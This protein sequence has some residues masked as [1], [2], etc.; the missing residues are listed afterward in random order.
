MDLYIKKLKFKAEQVKPSGLSLK[1]QQ[2]L[3]Q[4]KWELLMSYV[5][6]HTSEELSQAYY[7]WSFTP[8]F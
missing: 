2:S 7:H 1:L 8:I 4:E 3:S 6:H 5:R